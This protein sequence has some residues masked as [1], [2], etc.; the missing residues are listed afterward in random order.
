M[1][2]PLS[3]FSVSVSV[4]L[5]FDKGPLPCSPGWLSSDL[6]A[7]SLSLPSAGIT[8]VHHTWPFH[9]FYGKSYLYVVLKVFPAHN[10]QNTLLLFIIDGV[11][12]FLIFKIYLL[13]F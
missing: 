1:P 9:C 6:R 7:S 3:V 5:C 10:A 8:G 13:F 2:F 4:S 11:L 12:Y